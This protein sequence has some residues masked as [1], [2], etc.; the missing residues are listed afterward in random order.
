ME[1]VLNASIHSS[2]FGDGFVFGVASSAYQTEGAYLEDGKGLSIW[3]LFVR[4]EGKIKDRSTGNGATHFYQ[5][6]IQDIILMQAL[7]VKN[8][9]FSLS[10]PR[11]IPEGVGKT[12]EQG[13]DFY[14]AVIDFCLECGIE[15]WVTLYHWDLPQALEDRGGWTNRDVVRWFEDY[16]AF[17]IQQ[18]GDRVKHWMVL[19]EP[20]AF[21]GAG[22][23]LGLHAPGRKGLANFLPAVHHAVLSLATGA[24][25][26]KSL[27]EN[28]IVGSTFSCAPVDPVD[29]AKP[30]QEA[31]QRV[32]VLTNRLFIEPVL[33]LGYPWQDLKIL[34]GLERYVQA[35]DEEMLGAR[36]DFIGLQNYTREVVRHSTLMPYINARQVKPSK[37]ALPRTE[38]D[39]EVYPQGI[40]RVLKR[41]AEY[42]GMDKI[43]ITENGAAFDDV[44]V[45]GCVNDE[46]RIRFYEAYLAQVLRAKREGVNV[47]GYFA[48]SFTDNFEW[49]EGF[50]KRFGLV[51]VDYRT[52]RRI[53]KA[54]GFWFQHFLA[55]Q[56]RYS[57]AV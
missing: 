19:N 29:E 37:R 31:A 35:G 48:W 20:M 32:D 15:P 42:K 13:V 12:N 41:F 56:M 36:L 10:W 24:R 21:T 14:N 50:R 26:I 57:Q 17:C 30:S 1:R 23:F 25:V 7:N 34:Q 33:G 11:L 39:W 9:R 28:L 54:S 49:A 18:F 51:Y 53:V 55:R 46:N 45:N 40:Y 3:D 22:Y 2:D 5:R 16:V 27:D 44:V 47:Q 6:Y 4:R 52:Q 8:F 38:M 43:I